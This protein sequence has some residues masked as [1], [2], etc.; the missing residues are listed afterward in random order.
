MR[1][2]KL[3]PDK[4]PENSECLEQFK[5]LQQ[6]KDVLANV[7]KR[8]DYDRW[9][10]SGIAIDFERWS[11]FNKAHSMHWATPKS[12]KLMIDADDYGQCSSEKEL[13]GNIPILRKNESE[14]LRKFRNYEI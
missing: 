3:H 7:E 1:A 6:A 10:N 14:I 12:S 9:L 11:S 8:K 4:N 5:A 2:L 13:G